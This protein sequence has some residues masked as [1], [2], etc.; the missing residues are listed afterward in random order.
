MKCVL[1]LHVVEDGSWLERLV[2]FLRSQFAL[3]PLEALSGFYAGAPIRKDACHITVD[4]GDLSFGRVILPVL[5]KHKIPASL[6]VSPRACR[7]Q[8]NFW[9]QEIEGYDPEVLVQTIAEVLQT[10]QRLVSNCKITSI[11]KIMASEQRTEVIARYRRRTDV[12]AK[13]CH[14]MTVAE[15]QAIDKFGLVSIGAHTINH[16]ILANEDDQRSRY[17]IVESVREL[18]HLLKHEIRHF[19]YPNGISSLD[20]TQRE[21]RYLRSVGI[22]LAFTTEHGHLASFQNPLRIPRIQI[23]SNESIFS[24][25]T[26]LALGSNWKFV[27][28]L[29]PFGEYA[30]RKRLC[31]HLSPILRNAHT[32]APKGS[33][34][35]A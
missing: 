11:M 19:A 25:K 32:L 4:D 16:P 15:L 22:Q 12:S 7:E 17:E 34:A 18:A 10:P 31:R 21:E 14:N 27:K 1:T 2:C 28:A 5:T 30:E 9:F 13:P 8:T 35:R 33:G 20:F 23:S 6:F 24:V 26:K 29:D 3:V